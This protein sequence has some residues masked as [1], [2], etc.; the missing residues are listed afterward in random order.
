MLRNRVTIFP[1]F[2]WRGEDEMPFEK[3]PPEVVARFDE[4]AALAPQATRKPMFGYPSLVLDGHLFMSLYE[5]HL[6]L[7]LGGDDRSAL[8]D[9]GGHVFEP[10]AGRPMKDYVLVPDALVADTGEMAAWVQRAL[11]HAASLP[12]KKPK[13]PKAPK[14]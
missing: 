7:R 2:S 11:A 3:S 5:D 6:V 13:K 8:L 14:G 4:L 9:L 10:M 12:P 1:E